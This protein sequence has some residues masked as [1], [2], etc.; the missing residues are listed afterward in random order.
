ML[1]APWFHCLAL[2]STPTWGE[3]PR[4]PRHASVPELATLFAGLAAR[5]RAI[6]AL[7]L[8]FEAVSKLDGCTRTLRGVWAMRGVSR[9]LHAQI[10]CLE[11]KPALAWNAWDGARL[12]SAAAD[13][14][15]RALEALVVP[16]RARFD[17]DV[18]SANGMGEELL[19]PSLPGELGLVR[20]QQLWSTYLEA[21]SDFEVLGKEDLHGDSCW[22]ILCDMDDAAREKRPSDGVYTYPHVLW[23]DP[24]HLVMRRID[25]YAAGERPSAAEG[26]PIPA[27][28]RSGRRFR[29]ARRTDVE[30]V[31][32]IAPG[33][34][35]GV[36]G[37]N[38]FVTAVKPFVVRIR[39]DVARARFGAGVADP[40]L[41]VRAREGGE[42]IDDVPR[43]K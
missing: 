12:R 7:V 16:E 28:E 2:A 24:R 31:A 32:E 27:L 22:R 23:F 19:D 29:G 11:S 38:T 3:E 4:A 6:E 25:V 34:W 30:K 8:P 5:D 41:D 37:T 35:I 14:E 36:E 43:Q 9:A 15:W 10:G 33:F 1:F 17:V 42:S 18:L 26:D 21:F 40:L 20:V 13:G 39:V